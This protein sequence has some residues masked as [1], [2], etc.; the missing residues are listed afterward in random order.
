MIPYYLESFQCSVPLFGLW[1]QQLLICA[2]FHCRL[3]ISCT[4]CYDVTIDDH[5]QIQNVSQVSPGEPEFQK[6]KSQNSRFRFTLYLEKLL[7]VPCMEYCLVNQIMMWNKLLPWVFREVFCGDFLCA[8]VIT[9]V[10]QKTH[11]S[12]SQHGLRSELYVTQGLRRGGGGGTF[13]H[14]GPYL[15]FSLRT[16]PF[17]WRN[18]HNCKI[19]LHFKRLWGTQ[20]GKPTR[21]R[22]SQ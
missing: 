19:S 11:Q 13:G 1:V 17:R 9:R 2:L 4:L 8:G 18:P 6:I 10:A 22:L 16:Y 20:S 5:Q 12:I 14:L 3:A 7:A 15:W 21:S